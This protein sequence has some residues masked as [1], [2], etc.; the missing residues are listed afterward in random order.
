MLLA[1]M[2]A[3]VIL[4]ERP[5]DKVRAERPPGFLSIVN[6]NKKSIT[7]NLKSV[8]GQEIFERLARKSDVFLA[9]LRPDTLLKM[10]A[11]YETLTKVK[12]DIIYCAMTGYG[13]DSPYK[14]YPAHNNTYMGIAGMVYP[15]PGGPVNDDLVCNNYTADLIASMFAAFSIVCALRARDKTGRGQFIDVPIVDSAL[16]WMSATLGVFF[17]TGKL[18]PDYPATNFYRTS[19]GKYISLSALTTDSLW[20]NVCDGLGLSEFADLDRVERE[21]RFEEL[22]AAVRNIISQRTRDEWLEL[23]HAADAPCGPVLTLGELKDD[24]HIKHRQLILELEDD[25]GAKV[26]QMA[27]PVKFSEMEVTIRKLAPSLGEDTEDILH[28]LGYDSDEINHM[29]TEEAI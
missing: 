13:Q 26:E 27:F 17:A 25:R 22:E 11:D 3:E 10:G 16:S 1:D 4:I 23:L 20:R 2:G 8:K 14:D 24:Q 9:A 28:S 18:R 21:E 29:R 6:R 7:L 5:D 19:D 12:P 15:L